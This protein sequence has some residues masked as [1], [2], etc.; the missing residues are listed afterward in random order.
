MRSKLNRCAK[1]CLTCVDTADN[2]L[3][4]PIT[5][6]SIRKVV[7][8]DKNV[9][10]NFL[11]T[12]LSGF[13]SMAPISITEIKISN[14]CVE[15]C[16]ET[17]KG[18]SVAIN[19]ATR[20]CI[21]QENE[22]DYIFDTPSVQ[23]SDNVF[24][25]VTKLKLQYD[26][27]IN[28]AK[29]EFASKKLPNK[30]E[31]C[32]FRGDLK[33]RE[34]GD[35]DSYFFCRCN[36][37]YVGDNCQISLNV[38]QNYQHLVAENLDRLSNQFTANNHGSR[39]IFLESLFIMNKFKTSLPILEKMVSIIQ[40]HLQQDK[41]IENR[42]KLYTLF[43]AILLNLFDLM[44][45][46]KRLPLEDY[47][48]SSDAKVERDQIYDAITMIIQEIEKAFEDLKYTHS[49]LE[50]DMKHFISLDTYSYIMAEYRLSSYKND[51]GFFISNPNIDMSTYTKFASNWLSLV[52]SENT[53][54]K[55]NKHHIQALNL[56]ASLFES[57]MNSLNV[58]F[59][60]NIMYLRLLD[61]DMPHL[62]IESNEAGILAFKFKFAMLFI[63]AYEDL[64]QY[65][66]CR[67][68][69]FDKSDYVPGTLEKF[70]D[71]YEDEQEDE[72]NENAYA[73]CKFHA[74]FNFRSY[75]FT[76]V[77]RK[78]V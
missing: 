59:L 46:Q 57:K 49:F 20:Q 71:A 51:K 7:R 50:Y 37:G 1:S 56:S 74:L 18:K 42:K 9:K 4:C 25:S 75:Y 32:S 34:R 41:A 13:F 36:E 76:L 48:S 16:P 68:Y 52:F 66:A 19:E 39:K 63:P 29:N 21:A 43:D 11:Q 12:I 3:K 8:S 24:E 17:A 62:S 35:Y 60:S 22:L 61:P 38:A 31:K 65:L 72:N 53:D 70:I 45:D 15:K 47:N 77:L 30:S 2:C 27:A 33:K 64:S 73:I 6:Y 44:D 26:E 58:T 78:D 14:K 54:V 67:A 55:D 10:P 40:T 23:E 69:N 5:H 28:N